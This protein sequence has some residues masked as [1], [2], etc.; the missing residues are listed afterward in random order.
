MPQQMV[1][2]HEEADAVRVSDADHRMMQ[3]V[4]AYVEEHLADAEMSVVQMSEAAAMSRSVLQRKMKTL[5]G[6]TPGEFLRQA[7]IRKACQLLQDSSLTVSEV[8]FQCGFADPKY[9][10]RTFRQ[11]MGVTPTEYKNKNGV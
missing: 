4:T 1:V 11:S 5:M 6:V 7:R 10:S 3:R 2:P 9:F 8:A